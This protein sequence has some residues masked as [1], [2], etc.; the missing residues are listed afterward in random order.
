MGSAERVFLELVAT[1]GRAQDPRRWV[2]PSQASPET[3]LHVDLYGTAV[4]LEEF[5]PPPRVAV[6][7]QEQGAWLRVRFSGRTGTSVSTPSGAASDS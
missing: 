4:V 2:S 7:Q 3:I 1:Y 5:Q 6:Q